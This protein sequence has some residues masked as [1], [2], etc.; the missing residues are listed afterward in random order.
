[1]SAE[2]PRLEIDYPSADETIASRHYAFRISSPEPLIDVE[3][4]VDRGPWLPCRHACGLWWYDWSDFE[5]GSHQLAA[6]GTTR[7]GRPAN[8]TFRRFNVSPRGK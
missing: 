6:R 3:V 2:Q 7:D 1:M 5:P 4:S 8:S